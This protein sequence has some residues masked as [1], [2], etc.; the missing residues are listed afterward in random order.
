MERIA[1]A[2]LVFGACFASLMGAWLFR[3]NLHSDDTG[4]LASLIL[5]NSAVAAF[6]LPRR[7]WWVALVI[8][9]SIVASEFYRNGASLGRHLLLVTAFVVVVCVLGAGAGAAAQWIVR[10]V[11]QAR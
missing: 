4:I 10:A 1:T 8:A 5:I 2:R 6:I 7:W 11:G 3:V 9:A